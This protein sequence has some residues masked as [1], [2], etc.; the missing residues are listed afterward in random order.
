MK[1]FGST[2]ASSRNPRSAPPWV[3]FSLAGALLAL[4][5]VT[6]Q[7][8]QFG[9]WSWQA[10]F[11]A[12]ARA[13]E[14]LLDEEEISR[15]DQ[16]DFKFSFDVGGFV[17]HPAILRFKVGVDTTLSSVNTTRER[18]IRRW[19]FGAE[20]T[21]LPRGARTLKLYAKR[22][23]HSY[24]DLT[25][26]DPLSLLGVPD[27]DTSFGGRL[28]V[29]R[30]LLQGSLF[31]YDRT[32]VD[33]EGPARGITNHEKG[34]FQW[35]R[36][37]GGHRRHVRLERRVDEFGLTDYENRT[38]TLNY[39]QRGRLGPAWRWDAYSIGIHRDLDFQGERSSFDSLRTSQ[40]FQ[41]PFARDTL[42]LRYDGGFARA[43]GSSTHS[44]TWQARYAWHASRAWTLT[45]FVGYG[46]QFDDGS[47]LASPQ[48]GMGVHWSG[49]AGPVEVSVNNNLAYLRLQRRGGQAP[50]SDS[51]LAT[52]VLFTAR[53]GYDGK[54]GKELEAS[55][56]RNRL[57]VAGEALTDLPDLGVSTTGLGTENVLR[58]RFTLRWRWRG[59][60]FF[61]YSEAARRTPSGIL[62]QPTARV[63]RLS[64]TFQVSGSRVTLAGTIGSTRV[65]APARQRVD[66]WSASLG[67]RPLR[68]L[69]LGASYRADQR[70]LTLGPD[71][72]SERME[73]HAELWLGAFFLKGQVFQ[74]EQRSPELPQRVN[75]GLQLS[76]TRRF[77][78]WLPV[79]T[80]PAPGGVIR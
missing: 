53:H 24:Q 67:W 51:T 75:R 73:G 65:P 37:R 52:A 10:A 13:T 74:T 8:Q 39:D 61:G 28:R 7:A 62:A 32:L 69:S 59:L 4:T 3:F 14:N 20:T 60:L 64:H 46:L 56:L 25:Q 49:S 22:R 16:R 41:R 6:M 36:A 45:P 48:L 79:V 57:R 35:D 47:S 72:D 44:H 15:F 30:G 63:D 21:L 68:L 58:G 2:R 31:G 71:V 77:G 55:W 70:E 78:G 18:R 12:E 11:G 26:D 19:G 29:R 40:V 27:R 9:Q 54:L 43:A 17:V 80:A 1:G 66:T 38:L 76:L 50:G 23:H 5:P 42:D 33:F 34:F